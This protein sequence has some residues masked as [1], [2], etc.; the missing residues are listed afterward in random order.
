M[1]FY[2]PKWLVEMTA[3]PATATFGGWLMSSPGYDTVDHV[4]KV[5]LANKPYG[6]WR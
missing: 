5:V 6:W 1:E 3:L 2:R 4:Q